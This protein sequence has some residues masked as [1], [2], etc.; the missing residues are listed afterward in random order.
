MNDLERKLKQDV[1]Y[2]CP[3]AAWVFPEKGRADIIAISTPSWWRLK[4]LGSL[5]AFLPYSDCNQIVFELAKETPVISIS[6]PHNPLLEHHEHL[7]KLWEI[8]ISGVNPL[9]SELY[10]E[11][12]REQIEY[13]GMGWSQEVEMI[14]TAHEM[15]MLR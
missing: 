1:L 14:K 5:A 9:P 12:F 7:K 8:G 13:I 10:D 11:S 3:I 2:L 6:G 4:G 15:N